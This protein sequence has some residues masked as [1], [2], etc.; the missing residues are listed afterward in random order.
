MESITWNCNLVLARFTSN[1][2]S[3]APYAIMTDLSYI[4]NFVLLSWILVFSLSECGITLH[5]EALSIRHS[6]TRLLLF[7]FISICATHC[8]YFVSTISSLIMYVDSLRDGFSEYSN[9]CIWVVTFCLQTFAKWFFYPHTSFSPCWVLFWGVM[10]PF[11]P[12][13]STRYFVSTCYEILS[14]LSVSFSVWIIC[15][16]CSLMVTILPVSSSVTH[17]FLLVVLLLELSQVLLHYLTV[18]THNWCLI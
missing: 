8:F 13:V 1:F 12:T 3:I 14:S 15:L 7:V 2:I 9:W 18:L 10:F 16:I 6:T 11:S 17:F 5:D 4:H